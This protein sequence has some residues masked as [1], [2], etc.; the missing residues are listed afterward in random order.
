MQPPNSLDYF[1]KT[2]K[3]GYEFVT[4]LSQKM[5]SQV[6]IRQETFELISSW[7][8]GPFLLILGQK[9]KFSKFKSHVLITPPF[10]IPD[11]TFRGGGFYLARKGIWNPS[12]I[13]KSSI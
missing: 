6:D 1:I 7:N 3:E 4:F 10:L 13:S 2:I 12:T 5:S 11:P 8:R 9:V